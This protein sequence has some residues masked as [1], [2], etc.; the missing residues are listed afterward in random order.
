MVSAQ[1]PD[2][3]WLQRYGGENDEKIYALDKNG[4]GYIIAGITSLFGGGNADMYILKTD[5]SGD[6][7]WMTVW[8]T[9]RQEHAHDVIACSSGGYAVV[10]IERIIQ[11]SQL[12]IVFHR[13]NASGAIIITRNCGHIGA[14]DG[15]S[16]SET[17]DGVDFGYDIVPT[18]DGGYVAAGYTNFVRLDAL[19]QSGFAKSVLLK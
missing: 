11:N 13:L 7:L 12:Q 6:S 3:T 19:G 2:V 18:S 14:D 15:W 1:A 17:S 8:G 16:V 5:A 4:D 9:S 10:G